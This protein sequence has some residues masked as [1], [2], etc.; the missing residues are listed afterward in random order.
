MLIPLGSTQPQWQPCREGKH[1]SSSQR[2]SHCPQQQTCKS[3]CTATSQALLATFGGLDLAS[4]ATAARK[5]TTTKHRQS[6]HAPYKMLAWWHRAVVFVVQ[7]SCPHHGKPLG[8][9]EGSETCLLHT[10]QQEGFHAGKASLSGHARHLSE[11][12]RSRL[13][14]AVIQEGDHRGQ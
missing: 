14:V 3:C 8:T 13:P 5:L 2:W 11:E 7:N 10:G 9:F 6:L 1:D 12:S 4:D